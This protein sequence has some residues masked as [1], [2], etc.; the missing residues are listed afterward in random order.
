MS[1]T[2]SLDSLR[3][4]MAKQTLNF[5]MACEAYLTAPSQMTLHL[6]LKMHIVQVR[7]F[8]PAN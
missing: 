4:P 3:L 6:S 7:R 2:F 1:E 8:I 5:V